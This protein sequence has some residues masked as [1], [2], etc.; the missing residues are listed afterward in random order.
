MNP[1]TLR[2]RCLT[3]LATA[4]AILAALIAGVG[5]L[6]Q[7]GFFQRALIHWVERGT[8]RSIEVNGGMHVTVFAAQPFIAVER[9]VIGNPPW[10]HSGRTAEIERLTVVFRWPGGR[11]G[12]GISR[13]ELTGTSLYLM[14]DADGHA[15]WQWAN[16]D[17][18]DQQELPVIRSVSMPAARVKLHDERRHLDFAGTVSA[19]EVASTGSFDIAG[20]GVLNGRSAD[21]TVSADGLAEAAHTRPYHFK[22]TGRSSGSVVSG[23][24]S[25]PHPFDFREIDAAFDTNGRDLKDL[26]FLTGVSLV[27]TGPFELS[28]QLKVRG[29]RT[30]FDHLKATFGSSDVEGRIGFDSSG[31]RPTLD[32]DFESRRLKLADVGLRAAGREPAAD[33]P[34][35]LL[36]SD[37]GF[38]PSTLRK[39]DGTVRLRARR[40]DLGRIP[41]YAFSAVVAL[42]HAI[43]TVPAAT[44]DVLGGKAAGRLRMDATPQLPVSQLELRLDKL[45]LETLAREP[46]NPPVEGAWSGLVSLTGA[47][48]SLHQAAAGA[49]GTVTAYLPQGSIRSSLAEL[50]GLDLRGLGLLLGKSKDKTPV[51]CAAAEFAAVGGILTARKLLLDTEQVLITG[52]GTVD[53]H[54]ETLALQIRGYP[55][56]LRLFRLRSALAVQGTLLHPTVSILGGRASLHIVDPGHGHDADCAALPASASTP[57]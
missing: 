20:T 19:L 51:R 12:S 32:G 11:L 45:H 1:S 27:N 49:S 47:G 29:S 46:D 24:G 36:F 55:K 4:S 14:R 30:T 41:L 13:V 44:A 5:L 31:V 40:I 10:V 26:Y 42:D 35:R 50:A 21:F 18:G 33:D 38:N 57:R 9:L 34:P 17:T 53:L 16:P 52:G 15:N 56:Y 28:G 2:R 43:V 23:T 7:S 37:A 25:L 3:W 54:G 8:G 48:T 39:L 6:V 22:F